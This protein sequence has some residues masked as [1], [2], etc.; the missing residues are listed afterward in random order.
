MMK[1]MVQTQTMRKAMTTAVCRAVSDDLPHSVSY[2]VSGGQA[3]FVRY[4]ARPP[5]VA[6]VRRR[7]RNTV[8]ARCVCWRAGA[9][10]DAV[11]STSTSTSP[12]TVALGP[13]VL[14]LAPAVGVGALEVA[15]CVVVVVVAAVVV[16]VGVV[17]VVVVVVEKTS[18]SVAAIQLAL[19]RRMA[20][21]PVPAVKSTTTEGALLFLL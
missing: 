5:M 6:R 13:I 3:E 7:Q 8:Y 11:L 10:T 12:G 19:A 14:G 1:K 9:G 17:V 2:R 21:A 16:V 4:A 20:A 18:R 15:R